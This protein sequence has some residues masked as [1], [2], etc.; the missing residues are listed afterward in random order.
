MASALPR[1][2]GPVLLGRVR[3]PDE[4]VALAHGEGVVDAVVAEYP[5]LVHVP[6]GQHG[7]SSDDG[8]EAFALEEGAVGD[9]VAHDEQASDDEGHQELEG[10]DGEGVADLDEGEDE[11]GV[12]GEVTR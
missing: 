6:A 5:A 9:V 10:E 12:G 8:A 11:D 2:H 3:V 4:V 7:R 1:P